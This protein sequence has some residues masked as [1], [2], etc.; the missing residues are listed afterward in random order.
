MSSVE[1]EKNSVRFSKE[2]TGTSSE[3][4]NKL[5]NS[6]IL[7]TKF[8]SNLQRIKNYQQPILNEIALRHGKQHFYEVLDILLEDYNFL[9][10]I[11]ERL[12]LTR[13]SDVYKIIEKR[14][15]D[16]RAMIVS[17]IENF[18]DRITP[19]VGE[20]KAAE[21]VRLLVLDLVSRNGDKERGSNPD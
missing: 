21:V 20:D 2:L 1:K 12:N 18:R 3:H 14:L 19:Y 13:H 16:K 17:E 9:E 5:T 7:L 8:K 6:N 15:P 11:R 10:D 4:V